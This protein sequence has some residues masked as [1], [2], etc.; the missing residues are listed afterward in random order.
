VHFGSCN[1]ITMAATGS[2][3]EQPSLAWLATHRPLALLSRAPEP[4]ILFL[5]GAVAGALGKTI[6]APL[7]RLKIIM[8]VK[9]KM[10]GGVTAFQTCRKHLPVLRTYGHALE[11]LSFFRVSVRVVWCR[12]KRQRCS[13]AR[14][15]KLTT[16]CTAAR[17][18]V[19]V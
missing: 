10:V 9:G 2:K 1:D 12:V 5:A 11:S 3:N 18:P 6:T 8:Q 16:S 15:R 14:S 7:D 17:D 4:S 13:A 19:A